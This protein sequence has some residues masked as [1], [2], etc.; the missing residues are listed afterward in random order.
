MF[1]RFPWRKVPV[2]WAAQLLGAF[3]GSFI[4]YGLYSDA[5]DNFA[6][7]GVREVPG[8]AGLFGTFPLPYLSGGKRSILCHGNQD[9]ASL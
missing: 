4:T 5:I 6:G 7:K 1:R 3:F 9:R 8:T 2:F